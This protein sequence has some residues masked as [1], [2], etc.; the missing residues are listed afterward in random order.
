M[1]GLN[2]SDRSTTRKRRTQMGFLNKALEKA[3]EVKDQATVVTQ[4]AAA[5][6]KAAKADGTIDAL[7]EAGKAKLKD[8]K[9]FGP[10]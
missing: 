6:Y 7:K 9:K 2:D 10:K 5:T 1:N 3:K 4:Q 8:L